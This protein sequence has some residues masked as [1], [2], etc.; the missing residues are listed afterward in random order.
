ML[1]CSIR[2]RR[3]KISCCGVYL[4]PHNAQSEQKEAAMPDGFLDFEF[5]PAIEVATS[6]LWD[7]V[8]SHVTPLEWRVH[9]PLIAAI[10][11]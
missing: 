4:G 3:N 5:T 11:E 7:K 2:V 9:A 8:K 6:A 10:N 1:T